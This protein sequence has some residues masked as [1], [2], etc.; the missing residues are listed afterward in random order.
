MTQAEDYSITEQRYTLLT[1]QSVSYSK[2]DWETLVGIAEIRL[3][4]FLCLDEFPELTEDNTDLGML[5]A[6]FICAS[7]KFS[8]DSDGISSKSVRNFT[9][10]F[11]SSATN[12]F[13][14]IYK[15][16]EDII[17]KYSQCD[18]GIKVES[19]KRYCCGNYNNGLV[20]F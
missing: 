13:Q 19:S 2:D 16:Y 11:K 4:S 8:G 18:L 1:G 5:L 10:S 6:N 20:N 14:Q 12:A 3:A 17:E 9:I 7:I 15:Q